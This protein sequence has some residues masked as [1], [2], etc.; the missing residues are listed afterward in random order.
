[1]A[2][3]AVLSGPAFGH[4]HRARLMVRGRSAAPKVGLFQ[5]GTHR[6]VDIPRC[7]VHHPRINEV[8]AALRRAVR[9]T[10][11]SPYAERPHTGLLRAVQVVVERASRSA[12]VVLV[13]RSDD[14]SSLDALAE[15]L[16]AELGDALQ[17]LF[18]NGNPAPTNAIL[19]PH[20]RLLHGEPW[21]RESIAGAAVF[22]PPGA[23]GQGNLPLFERIAAR[24]ASLVPERARVVE[25]HAGCG[26]LG[27]SLLPRAARVVM[28]EREP[29]ALEGLARGLAE[30]PARLRERAE[31]APGPAAEHA[32][33]VAEADCVV[34]DPPR[35]GLDPELLGALRAAPPARLVYVSCGL[36]A[37]LR[38]AAELAAAGLALAELAVFALFPYT[39]H[40][41]TVARFDRRA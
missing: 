4:R 19:G 5:A 11:T 36:D 31:L 29:V 7:A 12:Q 28:N 32:A 8:A 20:W 22:F 30:L 14:P 23:F 13:A 6:V 41:E 27:L 40:V 21:L 39:E 3:P 1:M 18:W 25:F 37:F 9:A 17:G 15:A 10:G 16:R 35:R 34:V 26:A 33:R 38:E 24:V 2:P